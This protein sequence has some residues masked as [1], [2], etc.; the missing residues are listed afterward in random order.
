MG[1]TVA[2]AM[3]SCSI[4]QRCMS[5]L[6]RSAVVWDLLCRWLIIPGLRC[7]GLIL[8]GRLLVLSGRLVIALL[9]VGCGVLGLLIS[10]LKRRPVAACL[11]LEHRRIGVQLRRLQVGMCWRVVV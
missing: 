8:S 6:G 10:W 11:R 3:R 5:L 1:R 9:L 2:D 7:G 4:W